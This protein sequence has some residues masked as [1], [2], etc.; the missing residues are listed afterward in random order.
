MIALPQ[1]L[2]LNEDSKVYKTMTTIL[3]INVQVTYNLEVVHMY[4][5]PCSLYLLSLQ[6]ELGA[7]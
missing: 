6:S 5:V 4:N 3:I 1:I 7:I 2:V